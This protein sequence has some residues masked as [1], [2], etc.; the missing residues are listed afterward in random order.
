M[1]ALL[2][3]HSSS[4]FP[5]RAA[6]VVA[7]S[8]PTA[9]EPVNDTSAMR[10]SATSARVPALSAIAS[11]KIGGSDNSD[12]TRFASDCT[13]SAASGVFGDGFHTTA[14]PQ[15][16]ASIAFHAQTATGKLKAE[17]T[18]TTPSGCH[19]SYIRCARRSECIVLP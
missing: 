18:P 1:I 5:K 19:C 6:T 14:L 12:I 9:D 13:A 4:T 10:G 2:P 17:I 11:V 7:M 16:A 8:R 3:A 15:I